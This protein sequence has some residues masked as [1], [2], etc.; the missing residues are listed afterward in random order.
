MKDKR[1]II[2]L[3][4]SIIIIT[5][6]IF[7]GIELINKSKRDYKIEKITD[8]KYYTIIKEGKTGVID[9]QGRTIIDANYDA[10]KIPNPLK[11]VFICIYDYDSNTGTHKSKV[12]NDKNEE[13]FKEYD[14]VTS[15]QIKDIVSSV[16]YEKSVLKYE[17]DNKYGL[18][19]FEGKVIVKP[20]YDEIESMPYKE[21]ELLVKKEDK[22][23]VINIKGA[24]LIDIKYDTISGD[25]YYSKENEYKLGGYIVGNKTDEGYRYGYIDN[26][27]KNI[28][29]IEHNKIYRMTEIED[30][31]NAYLVAEK[32]G[33][34]GLLKNG[35]VILNYEYEKI[36][37]DDLNHVFIIEKNNKCGVVDISGKTIVDI[38]YNNIT[39][40]GIYIYSNKEN[41]SFIFD[42][43]GNR[44]ETPKY[45]NIIATNNNEYKIT[46]D[47]NYKYG[48]E[49]K[50]G[51][52]LI[53]NKYY[54][55]EYIFDDYFIVSG[56]EGKSGIVNSK[57]ETII[58]I[59]YDV[60]QKIDNTDIIQTIISDGNVLE[61]YD[62]NINKII[63]IKNARVYN[64]ENYIKVYSDS[65]SKYFDLEGKEKK[66]TEIFVNN[67][68]FAQEKNGKWGFV[69]KQGNVKVDYNYDKATEFNKYGFAGIRI[70]GK[71]GV[72]NSNGE[73]LLQPIY[74]LEELIGEPE[75]IGKYYKVV[76]G[77]GEIYYTDEI[78][79][80]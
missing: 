69:D 27:G 51:Q 21:G 12:L 23:G 14:N 68:L 5:I 46:I 11:P 4:I 76:S 33:Q 53:P 44:Q 43:N 63:S 10:V 17:K 8:F 15:I 66:N 73:I 50:E 67:N 41:Q 64:G 39:I 3:A 29:K 56:A 16:P 1:K 38:D 24:K 30:D 55:L 47:S 70:N 28:L 79:E 9:T 52:I 6:L 31:N 62:K 74:K 7:I 32:N 75:F 42:M 65:E 35:Q 78:I 77:Y 18:I 54:Y 2:I 25:N 37:Y 59:K 13:I 57:N 34:A 80:E 45:K 26:K 60:V 71:W 61:L 20:I 48:V 49:N 22:Y 19:N 36:E 40:E 72:I 58:S